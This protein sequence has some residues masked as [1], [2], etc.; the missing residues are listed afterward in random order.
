M[1]SEK[2]VVKI[3]GKPGNFMSGAVANYITMLKS[4]LGQ[5]IPE[6]HPSLQFQRKILVNYVE[7]CDFLR[8]GKALSDEERQDIQAC[9]VHWELLL[10][11]MKSLK[12][13][14]GYRLW[15]EG[16]AQREA[17]NPAARIF[18]WNDLHCMHE[19]LAEYLVACRLVKKRADL[20]E[21]EGAELG[22]DF[23]LYEMGYEAVSE[24]QHCLWQEI[25][26]GNAPP[27]R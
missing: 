17:E 23:R 16:D 10:A 8:Q 5:P 18:S 24:A 26:N 13:P 9:V 2:T 19:A 11:K 7:V 14:E 3:S 1:T 4:R 27:G 15:V 25:R 21:D 22:N 6:M 20:T 12:G